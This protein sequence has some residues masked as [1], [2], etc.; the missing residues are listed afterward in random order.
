MLFTLDLRSD[1]MARN[2]C[3]QADTPISQCEIN[4]DYY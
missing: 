1:L 3:T 2:T 4:T